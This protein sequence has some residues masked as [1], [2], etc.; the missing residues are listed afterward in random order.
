MAV[1]RDRLNLDVMVVTTYLNILSLQPDHPAALAALA[2]RYEAQGRYGDLVQILARQAE[3]AADPAARV[4]LHRRIASL[5][6]DKLGKHQNAVASFEKIFE[7]D[8]TDAET[9]ARAQGPLHPRR[10]PGGRSS[11]FCA[12]SSRTATREGR[13]ARLGEMAR[14]AG[15]RLNDTREA[16][17]L[18][19]QVLAIEARDEGAAGGPRD[20]VRAR[21]TLA[22]AG[23][24]PRAAAAERPGRRQD[25]SWALLE[26]RGTLLYERMAAS[27]GGAAIDV[28]S[29]SRRSIPR[30]PAPPRALP[31]STP[32]P[33]TTSRSRRCT[34]SRAPRRAV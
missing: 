26:R 24:D 23:G 7:A 11:S 25:G 6:A 13:R 4:A 31:R 14:I 16:I 20:A 8:P 3:A 5:W 18:Y 15:E 28:S 10:A 9:G 19:N 29:G 1:Y 2:G 34:R 21:A 27:E 22:G 12:R 30:T 33:A 17:A 32:R